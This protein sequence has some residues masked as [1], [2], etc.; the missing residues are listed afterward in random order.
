LITL[1]KIIQLLF[2]KASTLPQTRNV[3]EENPE[4]IYSY[5]HS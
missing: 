1:P 2:H 5:N 4:R 3:V